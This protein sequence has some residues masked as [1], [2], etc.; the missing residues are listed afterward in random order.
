MKESPF[1]EIFLL[2]NKLE[3]QKKKRR[4][5]N[6]VMIQDVSLKEK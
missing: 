1:F 2:K 6:F 5:K 3:I 4:K